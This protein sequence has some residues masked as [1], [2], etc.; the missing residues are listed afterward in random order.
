MMRLRLFKTLIL[1]FGLFVFYLSANLVY[2]G[3]LSPDPSVGNEFFESDVVFIGTVISE[4]YKYYKDEEN[5]DPERYYKLEV[6]KVFRGEEK[7]IIEVFS[8]MNSG[9]QYMEL[10]HTYVVFASKCHWPP[11]NQNKLQIGGCGNQRDVNDKD[12]ESVV[13]S[14]EK[15]LK[16]MNSGAGGIIRG[17]VDVLGDAPVSV[18]GISFIISGN[19]KSIKTVTDKTGWFR[20]TVPAGTYRIRP[21]NMDGTIL[22]AWETYDTPEKAIVLNGG[23]ADLEF[24]INSKKS[25][26]L[27]N[28]NKTL[29]TW[30]DKIK[31]L[32]PTP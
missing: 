28:A 1:A 15:V 19:G 5:K 17:K 26:Y 3:C 32:T 23:G 12:Y 18:S 6:K 14:L 29:R 25:D 31:R 9:G 24:R 30:E 13:S 8:E 20:V 10:H 27:A 16:D 21:K 7:P 22:P 4:R 11:W 2:A